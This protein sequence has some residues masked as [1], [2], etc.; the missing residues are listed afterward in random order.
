MFIQD[1]TVIKPYK[2]L[3]EVPWPRGWE[4]RMNPS[5]G[6]PGFNGTRKWPCACVGYCQ[7]RP[8][9]KGPNI[10]GAD[11]KKLFQSTYIIEDVRWPSEWETRMNLHARRDHQT[12]DPEWEWDC[13]CT[14][15]CDL[16]DSCKG[17]NL[18]GERFF[19]I[20]RRPFQQYAG[21]PLSAP[22][23]RRRRA[24]TPPAAGPCDLEI[25]EISP[26]SSPPSQA[27]SSI[28][29]NR[30]EY[31]PAPEWSSTRGRPM[32]PKLS[33]NSESISH[34][35]PASSPGLSASDLANLPTAASPSHPS[36]SVTS[37]TRG[38]TSKG[39]SKVST[40]V[41]LANATRVRRSLSP[42]F[43]EPG[44][45]RIV[46][47]LYP[48]RAPPRFKAPSH[49]FANY[50]HFAGQPILLYSVDRGESPS[51]D[52][53]NIE[54]LDPDIVNSD[55]AHLRRHVLKEDEIASILE[56]CEP[57]AVAELECQR[58]SRRWLDSRKSLLAC[59][60]A[61]L[62]SDIPLASGSPPRYGFRPRDAYDEILGISRHQ[63]APPPEVEQ[64]SGK[65]Q[66]RRTRS[67]TPATRKLY[68]NT[69]GR[70]GKGKA[71]SGKEGRVGKTAPLWKPPEVNTAA[72]LQITSMIAEREV[73]AKPPEGLISSFQPPSSRL[74]AIMQQTFGPE[75]VRSIRYSEDSLA[76]HAVQVSMDGL[77][78]GSTNQRIQRAL[79]ARRRN[80]EN[81]ALQYSIRLMASTSN[82][83][84]SK[85]RY[86][87]QFREVIPNP[88]RNPDSTFLFPRKGKKQGDGSFRFQG[89]ASHTISPDGVFL[90]V[91]KLKWISDR[92]AER[93][94]LDPVD[95]INLA[96]SSDHESEVLVSSISGLHSMSIFQLPGGWS[97]KDTSLNR[98]VIVGYRPTSTEDLRFIPRP[99]ENLD[100]TTWTDRFKEMHSLL[101]GAP[102]RRPRRQIWVQRHYVLT[103]TGPKEIF[104]LGDL[105]VPKSRWKAPGQFE[106]P[107]HCSQDWQGHEEGILNL[108]VSLEVATRS[109]DPR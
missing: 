83:R 37:S 82:C 14:G 77:S 76:A 87:L 39:Q 2:S 97:I 55:N 70:K 32:Q 23:R 5:P 30:A 54:F 34:V 38:E 56:E 22:S 74:E 15:T 24:Y 100:P 93:L 79:D 98:K 35:S 68:G 63:Q 4:V 88:A 31:G 48:A 94:G 109:R 36:P 96:P 84:L 67:S 41:R 78:K 95:W 71:A 60:R 59:R 62:R 40:A 19:E 102:A 101:L 18:L 50:G 52:S 12:F 104:R 29:Q 106:I 1:S 27:S 42:I 90:T 80:L 81:T 66:L 92:A 20:V 58:L 26:P 16:N 69:K 45:P 65:G 73:L 10:L 107:S 11:F 28:T 108:A 85:A 33:T 43:C 7:Q 25:G 44:S 47:D 105:A 51:Q 17:P 86:F 8:A 49:L 57:D 13:G 3:E 91:S 64:N 99:Q 89:K 53:Y 6:N 21:G 46:E 61:S 72:K 103:A 9:C 75:G